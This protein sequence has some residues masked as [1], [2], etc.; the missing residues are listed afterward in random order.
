MTGPLVP[1]SLAKWSELLS[2]RPVAISTTAPARSAAMAAT[3]SR[4]G[5][6]RSG[7]T[8][9][10]SMSRTTAEYLSL[11][12]IVHLAF[13]K[14]DAMLA[15]QSFRNATEHG[16]AACERGVASWVGRAGQPNLRLNA[17]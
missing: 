12:A 3:L 4:S 2:I 13:R 14:Q 6:T 17:C 7:P 11:L 10:P 9:V 5:T 15:R 1:N 16:V 8:I